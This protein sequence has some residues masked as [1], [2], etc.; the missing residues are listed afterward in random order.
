MM[1]RKNH[2]RIAISAVLLILIVGP[3]IVRNLTP[4]LPEVPI[5]FSEGW[6]LDLDTQ[7]ISAGSLVKKIREI[8]VPK[9]S[10]VTI[11]YNY[12]GELR[13]DHYVA[14]TND[15]KFNLSPGDYFMTT[16]QLSDITP[17]L[18]NGW[19]AKK[20]YGTTYQKA[21]VTY[22]VDGMISTRTI[23]FQNQVLPTQEVPP[24]P[25]SPF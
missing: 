23:F 17:D 15:L 5:E 22:N 8:E 21:I 20:M 2:M 3:I 16:G 4:A 18:L 9:G 19:L 11:I 25:P 10:M 14:E 12:S 13:M 6:D 7:A 1:S 24:A